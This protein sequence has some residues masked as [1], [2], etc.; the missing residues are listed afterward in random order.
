[1]K[2]SVSTKTKSFKKYC[3]NIEIE[4]REEHV[5]F[6]DN[7]MPHLNESIKNHPLYGAIFNAG[8]GFY[9]DDTFDI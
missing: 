5:H 7:V 8:N 4:S 6:H 9:I 2:V 3:I 1:M